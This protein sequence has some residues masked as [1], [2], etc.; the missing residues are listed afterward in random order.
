MNF[1]LAIVIFVWIFIRGFQPIEMIEEFQPNNI[2][3]EVVDRSRLFQKFATYEEF[4]ESDIY[5]KSEYITLYPWSDS[6][7]Y[8]AGIRGGDKVFRID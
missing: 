1:L 4:Q 5:T 6:P 7:A 2:L 3:M 8:T